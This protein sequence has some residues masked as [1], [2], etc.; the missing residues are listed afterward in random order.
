[1]TEAL[2]VNRKKLR[3]RVNSPALVPWNSLLTTQPS[4][5]Y[6]QVYVPAQSFSY[7]DKAHLGGHQS[8]HDIGS[9][10][11]AFILPHRRI[12]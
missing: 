8:R 5:T 12:P 7:T 6:W 1:M 4:P 2:Y 10:T 11:L 3:L 9:S